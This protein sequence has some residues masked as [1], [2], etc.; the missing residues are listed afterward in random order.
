MNGFNQDK[1]WT[2][3]VVTFAL[4]FPETDRTLIKCEAQVESIQNDFT[5]VCG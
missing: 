5:K 1:S 4:H 2:F 3:N